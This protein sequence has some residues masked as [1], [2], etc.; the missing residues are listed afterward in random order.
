MPERLDVDVV[1]VGAGLAGLTAARVLA[2]G[3]R[4]VAVL[5]ARDRVGGRLLAHTFK[6]GTVVEAGG[7]WIGPGQLRANALVDELGLE[8]F[9]T[10]S[11][12]E[13]VFDL[14]GRRKRFRGDVP[15]FAPA[16]LLD[17]AQSQ[18]RFDRLA[19]RVPLAA[20]WA[21]DRADAWDAETFHTWIQR[22]AKTA[23]ARWFWETYA[24][25]V[26]AAAPQDFSL[27]HA[28]FYTHAGQGVNVLIG[29]RG[30]AQ[31]DRVVGGSWLL[32]ARLAEQ[33]DGAVRLRVPVREIEQL[34]DRVVVRAGG[35]ETTSSYVIVAVPPALAARIEYTPALPPLRD[36]LTQKT[37]AGS[38]IKINVRYDEPFWRADGLSGQSLGDRGPIRFTFDNSPPDGASGVLVCFL[39]GTEAR[40]MCARTEDERRRLVLESL[41]AYFGPRAGRPAEYH[42]LDWAAEPW[43]R[44]CYGAHLAPG[45]WTQF[46][47]ALRAPVG[48]I[49]WSG[50]ETAAAW[51]GYM[52]GAIGSGERAAAEILG[53]GAG[54]VAGAGA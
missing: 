5:E 2:A 20:P 42:E 44:G 26:F 45:V 40:G 24:S 50:T 14:R 15:P 41:T 3:G 13:H 54:A 48:R 51:N 11:D 17:L 36:Q 19:T 49:H 21:A 38:V 12:G 16:A 37:P 1:V 47:T 25:G 9:A 33:L 29:T 52:D 6:D 35:L 27:L 18:A 31:Q 32:A 4:T 34:E 8:R 53:A 23:G 43:T 22:N 30:G 10:Y 39:E 28:L 46:G 7:Q